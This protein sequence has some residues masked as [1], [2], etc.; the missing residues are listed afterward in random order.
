MNFKIS[1]KEMFSG[2]LFVIPSIVGLMVFYLI[3]YILM[4]GYSLFGNGNVV[5][6]YMSVL[7]NSVFN[8]AAKNTL[9]FMLISVPLLILL[10]MLL[11]IQLNKKLLFRDKLRTMFIIPL[12][13][14][15]A[16]IILFFEMMFDLNGF[17]NMIL[18]FFDVDAVNWIHS[19]YAML[20]IITIFIWKNI[21]Y[22]IVLF[23]AGL[24]GIPKSYYEAAELDGANAINKFRHITFIYLMPTSFF[25]LIIS[26]IN[27]FKVFK[28]IFILTGAYPNNSI[29]MLQH[30][31]NNLF[32]KLEYPKLVTAAVIMS[33]SI[34]IVVF[35]LF[36][37]QKKIMDAIS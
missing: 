6:S 23:L 27:S 5:D 14:P 7:S 18:N 20:V 28:E 34:L 10:S 35:V 32:H 15:V 24:Q 17:V 30:Y 3:P 37:V 29:Y 25:V 33:F 4:L 21:G 12:V 2:L 22:N 11:A 19:E 1:K 16:S 36:K 31:M 26:I 9:V 13:L 8:L